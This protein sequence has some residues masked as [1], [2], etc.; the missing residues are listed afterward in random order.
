MASPDPQSILGEIQLNNYLSVACATVISHDY[1]L[2]FSNEVEYVWNR[3]WTLVSAMYIMLRYLG[4]L[5]AM[6]QS[7]MGSSFWFGSNMVRSSSLVLTRDEELTKNA[8][9]FVSMTG[10]QPPMIYNSSEGTAMFLLFEIWGATIFGIVVHLVFMLR[11][12]AMYNRSRIVLGILLC[13]YI[14]TTISQLVLLGIINNPK[15]HLSIAD[16]EVVNMELCTSSYN[17]GNELII[18]Q[19]VLSTVVNGV[20]CSFAV[21]QCIRYSLEIHKV[22]GK[23][24]SNR[25][26]KLLVQESILYFVMIL[27]LNIMTLIQSLATLSGTVQLV[28]EALSGFPPY[29]VGPHLILSVREFHSRILGEHIDSGFGLDSQ[30]FSMSRGVIFMTP[31]EREGHGDAVDEVA[32]ID[33]E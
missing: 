32:E 5:V 14:P 15:T 29:I 23:W 4:L 10:V 16:V 25:Y 19:R 26:M 30:R 7:F 8:H 3:P 22:L 18:S 20:L 13:V 21:V 6:V 1:I 33:I 28:V 17:G 9:S 27:L 12:Y 24:Q 31:E 11:V 2:T